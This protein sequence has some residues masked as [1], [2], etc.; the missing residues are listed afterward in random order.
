[1]VS[2]FL[3]LTPPLGSSRVAT[4]KRPLAAGM[5]YTGQRPG[6]N[7]HSAGAERWPKVVT[8]NLIND[9]NC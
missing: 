3:I 1:V 7:Y 4:I 8:T 5:M 2:Y 9:I 6:N